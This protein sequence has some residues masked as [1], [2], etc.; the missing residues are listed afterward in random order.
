MRVL[1]TLMLLSEYYTQDAVLL[2]IVR[3]PQFVKKFTYFP[4]RYNRLVNSKNEEL[5]FYLLY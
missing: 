4:H 3:L 5:V 1:V 2:Y